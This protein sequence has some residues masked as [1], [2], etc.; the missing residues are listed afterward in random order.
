M[1][2]YYNPIPHYGFQLALMH[3]PQLR[4][5]PMLDKGRAA[6]QEREV[7]GGGGG[8]GSD[9]DFGPGIDSL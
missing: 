6:Q 2:T 7:T 3:S 4:A 9:D 8:G 5:V 1:D